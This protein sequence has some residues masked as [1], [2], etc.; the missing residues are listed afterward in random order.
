M[1]LHTYGSRPVGGWENAH[2]SWSYVEARRFGERMQ[3]R[4]RAVLE[5]RALVCRLRDA[6]AQWSEWPRAP[7]LA[8][9]RSSDLLVADLNEWANCTILFAERRKVQQRCQVRVVDTDLAR[10]NAALRSR[11]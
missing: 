11:S 4:R 8:R 3:S 6:P 1:H 2:A 10:A 9:A 7:P 5:K